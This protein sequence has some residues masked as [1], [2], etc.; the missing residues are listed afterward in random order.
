MNA[1]DDAVRK[2]STREK[3]LSQIFLWPLLIGGAAG[4]GLIGALLEDGLWDA[5][6]CALLAVPI[7]VGAF[8]SWRRD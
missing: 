8:F 3:N 4:I 5:L 6:Y 1:V 2:S 7:A